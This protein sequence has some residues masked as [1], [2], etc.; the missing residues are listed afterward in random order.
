[1]EKVKK[2]L[3]MSYRATVTVTRFGAAIFYTN[4]IIITVIFTR[5]SM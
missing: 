2:Y 3:H 1:M 5:D 4:I